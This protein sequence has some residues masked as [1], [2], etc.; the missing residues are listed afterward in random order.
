MERKRIKLQV[1]DVTC[2]KCCV[3]GNVVICSDSGYLRNIFDISVA[4][5][6]A[7]SFVNLIQHAD[8]A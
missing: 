4:N 5:V 8:L 7:G 6:R 2:F 1:I 3:N